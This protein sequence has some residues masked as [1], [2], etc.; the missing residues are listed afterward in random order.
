MS[1]PETD[2]DRR[3]RG[4]IDQFPGIGLN[5]LVSLFTACWRAYLELWSEHEQAMT[6]LQANPT[7]DSYRIYEHMAREEVEVAEQR[8]H[9]F[10][11]AVR[12]APVNSDDDLI[13]ITTFEAFCGNLTPSNPGFVAML[14]RRLIDR[15]GDEEPRV[16]QNEGPG[17]A[18]APRPVP[19]PRNLFWGPDL[20]R[21]ARDA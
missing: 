8:L 13:A 4:F 9:R 20:R 12:N 15:F 1:T 7:N 16:E 2:L 5:E 11:R 3:A 21:K 10:L 19:V 14:R 18:R 17:R 6:W